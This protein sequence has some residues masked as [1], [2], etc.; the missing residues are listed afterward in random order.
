MHTPLPFTS[1]RAPILSKRGMVECLDKM[2]A[3][4]T[5]RA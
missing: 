5:D 1:H 2:A 4:F 3:I